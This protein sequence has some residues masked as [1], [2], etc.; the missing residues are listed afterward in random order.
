VPDLNEWQLFGEQFEVRF[1]SIRPFSGHRPS[2]RNCS[3]PT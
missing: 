2:Q 3:Y 1:G